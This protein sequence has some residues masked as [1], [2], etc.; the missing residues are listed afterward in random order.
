MQD[1]RLKAALDTHFGDDLDEMM[2]VAEHG[3]SGGV[4]GFI[5][6]Y[7]TRK[8]FNEYEEEIEQELRDTY[9]DNWFLEIAKLKAVDDTMTFKNMCVWIVVEMYCQEVANILEAQA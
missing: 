2:M 3:C 1:S 6:Y 7:E 5:Y 8:F 9:G 4:S